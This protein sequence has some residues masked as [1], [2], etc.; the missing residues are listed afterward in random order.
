MRKINLNNWYITWRN[1]NQK[2]D[3][4]LLKGNTQKWIKAKVPG[5]IHSDLFSAKIIPDPY[6]GLN[7]DHCRWVEEKDWYYRT[8]FI[9]P[10]ISNNE[11][12]FLIFEGID[13]F[14]TIFLNGEKIG[15]NRNMFTPVKIDITDKIKKGKNKLAVKIASPIFSV[16]IKNK[17]LSDRYIPRIY[18]RKAQF[19]YGWDIIMWRM[20]LHKIQI[21]IHKLSLKLLQLFLL[22]IYILTLLFSPSS[23]NFLSGQK[24]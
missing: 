3:K 2:P 17:D 4:E 13:T 21:T 8:D 12:I 6:F 9:S 10:E 24:E 1:F 16:K 18:A 11:R 22:A 5:D 19:N 23:P 7:A 15:E 20:V 14:S